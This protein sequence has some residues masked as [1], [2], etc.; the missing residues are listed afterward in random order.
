MAISVVLI[1]TCQFDF[2][3]RRFFSSSNFPFKLL[4]SHGPFIGEI[5]DGQSATGLISNLFVAPLFK[6][7]AESTDFLMILGKNSG[8]SVAGRSETWS[9]VL[10]DLPSS[11][12]TVGQTEPR[13]R[14][15]APNTQG[16]KNFTGPFLSYQIAKELTRA[17]MSFGQGLD[18]EELSK[19][20]FPK[21]GSNGMRQRIKHVALYDK[22]TQVSFI[23]QFLKIHMHACIKAEGCWRSSGYSGCFWSIYIIAFIHSL[24]LILT[25]LIFLFF[26]CSDLEC[27]KD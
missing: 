14:V 12:Y 4:Q 18:F 6:Q 17:Q 11:I 9:V 27:Q 22:N 16:E 3:L 7:E 2:S 13:T 1:I 25:F 21:L 8:A 19:K 10:R 26:F 20:T 15:Y 23:K 5:E 24:V